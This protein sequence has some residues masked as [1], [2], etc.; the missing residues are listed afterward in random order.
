MVLLSELLLGV[1]GAE[2]LFVFS[3]FILPFFATSSLLASLA[4]SIGSL[5]GGGEEGEG[6]GGE[7]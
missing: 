4:I 7:A 5:E 3:S 1:G 6:R 2:P